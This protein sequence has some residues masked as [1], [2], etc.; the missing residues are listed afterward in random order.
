MNGFCNMEH[1]FGTI[2]RTACQPQNAATACAM[3]IE[4]LQYKEA[5]RERKGDKT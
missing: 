5:T 2:K 3:R 1:V 4:Q